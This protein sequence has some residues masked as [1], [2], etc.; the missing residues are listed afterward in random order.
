LIALLILVEITLE[1]TEEAIKKR[2]SRETIVEEKKQ[3]TQ[4]NMR[5]TPL[6]TSKHK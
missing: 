2:Q 1:N 5:W 6:C 4:H 3:K